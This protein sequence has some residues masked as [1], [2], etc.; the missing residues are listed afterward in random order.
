MR[1]RYG[2]VETGRLVID[3][4]MGRYDVSRCYIF[5]VETM[6]YRPVCD[7][8]ILARSKVKYYGAYPAGFLHRARHLLGVHGD[9]AVLHICG[10]LVR[11]YPYRGFGPN[12]KTLDLDPACHPDYLQDARLPF[13]DGFHNIDH[14]YDWQGVMIDRP[15]TPEDADHYVPGRDCLPTA[16]ELLRSGLAV[17]GVG[18]RVGIL[19]YVWPQPPKNAVEQAV[20]TVV[21]GRNNRA[22]LYTVFER[23]S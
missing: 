3:W 11:D 17:V 20:I 16:N 2:K 23:M 15:Y 22:R 14:D 18:C 13:P 7:T 4:S 19:D 1:P 21:T 10:G 12:D 8:W 9:D 5:L 6:S